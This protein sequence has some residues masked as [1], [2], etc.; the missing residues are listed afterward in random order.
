MQR[1]VRVQICK[2]VA[3]RIIK[4]EAPTEEPAAEDATDTDE[5]VDETAPETADDAETEEDKG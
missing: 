2:G 3:I 5:P 1:S 4:G